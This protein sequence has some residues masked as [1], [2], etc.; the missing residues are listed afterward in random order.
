MDTTSIVC[1]RESE[2]SRVC[3][4]VPAT[5]PRAEWIVDLQVEVVISCLGNKVCASKV[6]LELGDEQQAQGFDSR[7]FGHD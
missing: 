7:C 5:V 1:T 4:H 6:C 2:R 3:D